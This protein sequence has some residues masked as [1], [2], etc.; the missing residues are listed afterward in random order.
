[1]A[2]ESES[3]LYR[4]KSNSKHLERI[5]FFRILKDKYDN[6]TTKTQDGND[7]TIDATRYACEQ[8]W[9]H[10]HVSLSNRRIF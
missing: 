7:H 8:F 4:Y 1:M 5:Y 10:S 6:I 9:K 2:S 3:Y